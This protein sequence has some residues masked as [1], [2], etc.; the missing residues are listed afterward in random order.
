MQGRPRTSS[1]RP[2]CITE[3]RDLH[4]I[5]D[6]LFNGVPEYITVREMFLDELV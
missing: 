1:Q 5:D 3:N 6:F 2:L 4:L